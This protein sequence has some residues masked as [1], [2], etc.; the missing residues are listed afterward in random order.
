MAY[1][2]G[3]KHYPKVGQ[4]LVFLFRLS[5]VIQI[6]YGLAVVVFDTRA[7]D[8]GLRFHYPPPSASKR[9]AESI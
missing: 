8:T 4:A 5:R 2:A 9:I 7:E 1:A 3:D 6:R